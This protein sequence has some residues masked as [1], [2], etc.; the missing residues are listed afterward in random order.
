MGPSPALTASPGFGEAAKPQRPGKPL[1][2]TRPV[3][4][5]R[6]ARFTRLSVPAQR[7]GKPWNFQSVS[8]VMLMR[9]LLGNPLAGGG[10][11]PGE[12]AT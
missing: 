8:F 5:V 10:R 2:P 12:T 11:L 6:K 1:L 7:S 4:V 9:R 3:G